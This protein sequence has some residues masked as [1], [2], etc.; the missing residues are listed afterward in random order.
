MGAKT[1][2]FGPFLDYR[3]GIPFQ[4]V[5]KFIRMIQ[6]VISALGST[7]ITA[8]ALLRCG[9]LLLRHSVLLEYGG[10]LAKLC[11]ARQFLLFGPPLLLLLLA[12]FVVEF[13]GEQLLLD[14]RFEK[15]F[16]A[17]DTDLV[18]VHLGQPGQFAQA[19]V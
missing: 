7:V 3:F 16:G 2:W 19:G 18:H 1:P 10:T 5:Y 15:V 12:D 14:F 13:V 11:A 9:S 4:Q 17:A 6:F 8:I